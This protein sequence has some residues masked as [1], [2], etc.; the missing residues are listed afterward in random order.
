MIR[1][2]DNILCSIC[3]THDIHFLKGEERD[4]CLGVACVLEY[5]QGT[6]ANLFTLSEQLNIDPEELR[7][8]FDRLRINGIFSSSYNA[9]ADKVLKGKNKKSSSSLIS[10]KQETKIAWGIVAGM[11]SGFT[12]IKEEISNKNL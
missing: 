11:A 2:Y 9:R 10:P 4:G 1:K 8:P 12:G 7:V 5:M 3:N 6:A